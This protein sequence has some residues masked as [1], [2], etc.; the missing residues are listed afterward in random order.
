MDFEPAAEGFV[1]QVARD[2]TLDGEPGEALPLPLPLFFAAAA[3]G[4]EEQ[5][6]LPEH[7]LVVATR[8][9]LR[10]ARADMFGSHEL[11]FK[12]AGHLAARQAIGR[13]AEDRRA[14][15]TTPSG[16]CA[17][18]ASSAS[19]ASYSTSASAFSRSSRGVGAP[20]CDGGCPGD[21]RSGGSS[22]EGA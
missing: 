10:H 21:A 1:F 13:T 3:T 11:A 18:H 8:V 22:P 4:I 7:G 20:G 19:G 15:G 2:L 6:R 17:N 12:I 5:L 16:F 9:E 14:S